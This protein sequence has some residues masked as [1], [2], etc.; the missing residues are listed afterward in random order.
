MACEPRVP[1]GGDTTSNSTR[2]GCCD[3]IAVRRPRPDR[4]PPV[5]SSRSAVRAQDQAPTSGCRS[6]SGP[7]V[8]VRCRD[9]G[10]GRRPL[11]GQPDRDRARRTPHSA[12]TVTTPGWRRRPVIAEHRMRLFGTCTAGP[13]ARTR[14]QPPTG[15]LGPRLSPAPGHRAKRRTGP[16]PPLLL[17]VWERHHTTPASARSERPGL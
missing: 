7:R 8:S 1:M 12:A 4:P 13:G 6:C 11:V 3:R 17:V 9:T 10:P 5:R 14:P 16:P 15:W 2:R